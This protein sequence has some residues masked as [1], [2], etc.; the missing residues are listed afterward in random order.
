MVYDVPEVASS[1]ST[2]AYRVLHPSPTSPSERPRTHSR[3]EWVYAHIIGS[4]VWT[5]LFCCICL[6]QNISSYCHIRCWS[7]FCCCGCFL[8]LFHD[9]FLPV[10]LASISVNGGSTKKPSLFDYERLTPRH[11]FSDLRDIFFCYQTPLMLHWK[12]PDT[13]SHCA[14]FCQSHGKRERYSS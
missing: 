11:G 2:S 4:K 8:G 9:G 12:Y 5:Q 10:S 3:S 13:V 14:Y 7:I 6:T 1:T